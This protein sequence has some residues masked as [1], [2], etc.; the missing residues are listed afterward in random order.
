VSSSSFSAVGLAGRY[1]TALFDLAEGEGAL[2][3]IAGDLKALAAM[4]DESNDFRRLVASP[5]TSRTEQS[6]AVCAVAD[7]A[8]LS[9]LTSKF[10]GV[11]AGNRRLFALGGVVS[12]YLQILAD[13]RGETTAEVTSAK[14]LSESQLKAVTDALKTA[15]GTKVAVETRVDPGVL[16]GLIVKVGSRMVDSSLRSKLQQLRLS[17]K[18]I[19]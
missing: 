5:V 3:V 8:G 4:L 16:G 1:A 15:M 10:L 11:L 18:G 6:H 19:G 2:D 7:A 14:P 9:A 12:A 17:M 13:H